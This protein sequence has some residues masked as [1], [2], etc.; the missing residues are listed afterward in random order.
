[1]G[2]YGNA[3]ENG[4]TGVFFFNGRFIR[5]TDA[6]IKALGALCD[7]IGAFIYKT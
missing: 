5:R 7:S 3:G 6:N 1:M 4:I 2:L